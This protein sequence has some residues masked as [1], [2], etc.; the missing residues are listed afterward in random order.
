MVIKVVNKQFRLSYVIVVIL[1]GVLVFGLGFTSN[2]EKVPTKVYQV[3]IDGEIIGTVR[4]D[5]SFDSY[6]NDKEESIKK[7]YGVNKVYMPNGVTIKGVTTYNSKIDSNED[8]YKRIVKLKQFTIKGTVITLNKRDDKEYKPKKI[9]TLNKGI[10]DDAVVELIRSFTDD[11]AYT[12]YMNDSQKEIVDTGNIIRNIDIAED[13]TYKTEYMSIDNDIF[14]T[15]SDLAKYLLYG[16]LDKQ[17]EYVVQ[18]GDTIET[19]ANANKLNVQEFLI[20]NSNFK[21]E[22]ALLYAGQKVN[23]GLINPLISIV[24]E[25]NDVRDEEK[26]YAVN[27]SYDPN[28]L[29]GVER[30]EQEGENGLYRVSREYEYI[31]G[32]LTSTI[33]LN[34]VEL[35]PS[36]DKVVVRGDKEVPHIADLSYWAWPTDT[37]YTITTYYGYRWGSMHAAIDIYGPGHGSNIYAANNGTVVDTKAGCTPGNLGC[38]GRQGNYVVINHNIGNYYT[39]YMHMSTINVKVGQ[40][41]S[42]GQKIGTMGNTGEVY[43]VPSSYSPYAGTHLH[44]ATWRGMPHRGGS[45]F[46]PFNLY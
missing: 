6:I 34:T 41:V 44:F 14:T 30:V 22:N 32:Q 10:F 24:V 38:N 37:P 7:K 28:E 36:V 12:A 31:N 2:R 20:A 27:I 8:V 4:S 45:P 35:K 15:S 17:D 25:V 33:T 23:V 13:I 39:Q 18:E 43:P 26:N 5:K 11:E 1:I 46:N 42:R 3:Y 29:Q 16:T 40:V 19:V 21:S 9:Y